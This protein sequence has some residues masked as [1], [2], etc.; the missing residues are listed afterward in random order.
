MVGDGF[1]VVTLD[2]DAVGD[3]PVDVGLCVI[4]EGGVTDVDGVYPSWFSEHG[5]TTAVVRPDGY[6]F[7][8]ARDA[9]ELTR[10]LAEL[11]ERLDRPRRTRSMPS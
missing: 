4:A 11:G 7:G 8:T 2:P 6:V 10:V 1:H 5:C 3:L 9:T